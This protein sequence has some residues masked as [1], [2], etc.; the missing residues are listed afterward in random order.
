MFVLSFGAVS[1]FPTAQFLHGHRFSSDF[2]HPRASR[3]TGLPAHFA[4]RTVHNPFSATPDQSRTFYFRPARISAALREVETPFTVPATERIPVSVAVVDAS[5]I[6]F[7]SSGDSTKPS[8]VPVMVPVPADFKGN[9]IIVLPEQLTTLGLARS[10]FNSPA[11]VNEIEKVAFV[12]VVE[13]IAAPAVLPI[14]T[15]VANGDAVEN[16][17]AGAIDAI[18]TDV[19]NIDVVEDVLAPVIDV[20][21]TDVAN[22]IIHS[23]DT[24]PSVEEPQTSAGSLTA[25][26]DSFV[27]STRQETA[28]PQTEATTTTGIDVMNPS[29]ELLKLSTTPKTVS[30]FHSDTYNAYND[31]L[32]TWLKLA[33]INLRRPDLLSLLNPNPLRSAST[34]AAPVI[35]PVS[36]NAPSESKS[37]LLVELEATAPATES[38]AKSLFIGFGE[39]ENIIHGSQV[40]QE[41]EIITGFTTENPVEVTTEEIILPIDRQ[42]VLEWQEQQ[43]NEILPIERQP[44]LAWQEQQPNEILPTDRQPVLEWQEQQ[45]SEVHGQVDVTT[46]SNFTEEPLT[47]EIHI[48]V[49]NTL[50][51][52]VNTI[53]DTPVESPLVPPPVLLNAIPLITSRGRSSGF[54]YSF[55]HVPQ[56][57][58]FFFNSV[59]G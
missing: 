43:A 39:E 28:L 41:K 34:T 30:H 17:A 46:E 49:E 24:I 26:D 58:T 2:G 52:N 15:D 45:I 44:V 51:T 6:N 38:I 5:S 13:D 53:I 48:P 11:P 1:G 36:Q 50:D 20:I 4:F 12:D 7:A 32:N 8:H 14:A 31:F 59:A 57:G 47:A 19:A 3:F 40:N 35:A 23:A 18:T 33:S 42:P 9:Q 10:L 54:R 21:T 25:I 55:S 29:L 37:Q 27:L 22:E 56:R 16:V